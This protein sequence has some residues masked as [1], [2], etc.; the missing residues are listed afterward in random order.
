MPY[1]I[2]Q[3]SIAFKNAEKMAIK[4]YEP[5]IIMYPFSFNIQTLSSWDKGILNLVA[6]TKGLWCAGGAPLAL[7]RCKPN[8]INDWDLFVES[9]SIRAKTEAML[10]RMGF[11]RL[12]NGIPNPKHTNFLSEWEKGVQPNSRKVQII[13]K[14]SKNNYQFAE[15]EFISSVLRNFDIS[16]CQVGF[17]DLNEFYIT[18]AATEDI[19]NNRFRLLLFSHNTEERIAKYKAKGFIFDES[20]RDTAKEAEPTY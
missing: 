9:E 10:E 19:K 12:H 4:P 20:S 8:Q 18:A 1:L 17:K 3:F 14:H 16:V 5:E 7:Y 6:N 13:S 11:E 15:N 2:K